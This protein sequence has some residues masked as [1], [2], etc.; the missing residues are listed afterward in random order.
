M[1]EQISAPIK[2]WLAHVKERIDRN[3]E[4]ERERDRKDRNKSEEPKERQN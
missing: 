4:K 2:I 1:K 3:R